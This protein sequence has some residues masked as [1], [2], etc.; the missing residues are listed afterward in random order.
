VNETGAADRAA[1]ARAAVA[2]AVRLT[3]RHGL[4]VEDPVVLH[5][6]FSVRAHLRPAPVVARI[7]TWSARLRSD[8]GWMARE[9]DVVTH[10]AR[11]GAPVVAPSA[12]LPPGPHHQDGYEITFWTYVAP[13]PDRTATAGDCA[14]MLPDLHA[15][16]RTYPGE[17]PA[18]GASALDLRHLLDVV[19]NRRHGLDDAD[20]ALLHSA[21]AETGAVLDAPVRDHTAQA[22]HGDAHPGNLLPTAG[23]LLWIDFEEV[24]RG[25]V[26]WDFATIGDPA[27][28]DAHH[29]PDPA[30][31]AACERARA[32]QIALCLAGLRDTFADVPGWDDGLRWALDSL[33]RQRER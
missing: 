10:L 2:A 1:V 6:T 5:D 18:L 15:A 33:A 19:A 12:E 30:L 17:L 13:D 26:E 23:E 9:V 14:R 32:L 8:G 25:P 20:V 7:P 4:R 3:R 24:C 11:A 31:L 27:A 29:D 16:L 28:L 22:L 21:A